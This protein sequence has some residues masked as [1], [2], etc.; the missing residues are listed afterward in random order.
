M[1]TLNNM[2]RTFTLTRDDLIYI[3][4]YQRIY[5]RVLREAKKRDNDR[6]VTESVHRTKTMWQLINREIGKG[7]ENEQKLELRIGNKFISNPAEI[8][9]KLIT[10]FIS[11][12]RNG[13]TK[14]NRIVY[15]VKIKQCP[16]SI[17]IYPVTEKEPEREAHCR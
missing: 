5:K 6:N 12:G 1:Q 8:T 13:K 14:D 2:K 4:N 16:N 17:F 10:H 7:P 15:N 9:D 11:T 3:E